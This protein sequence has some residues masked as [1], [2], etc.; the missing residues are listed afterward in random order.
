LAITV[1]DPAT[2]QKRFSA[3]TFK[4]VSD[5]P[6]PSDIWR[7]DD[8]ELKDYVT[9][10]QADLDRGLAFLSQGK[11]QPAADCFLQALH[12]N[13]ANERART[14][15]SEYYFQQQQY[16]KVVELYARNEITPETDEGT[17]LHVAASLN[18]TGQPAK[19]V[20]FLESALKLK[21]PSGPLYLALSDS[22]QHAGNPT[23]AEAFER[24]GRALMTAPP[25]ESER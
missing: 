19:A 4:I 24:K 2:Q 20:S 7:L 8:D 11:T 22:Y 23:Q 13:P 1:F 3:F 16:A 17:I 5:E 15:L 21:D 10:G 12:Y 18:K 6:S 25:A 9:S 14:R